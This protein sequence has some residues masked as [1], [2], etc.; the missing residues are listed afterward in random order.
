MYICLC[1]VVTERQI[2]RAVHEGVSSLEE[3]RATLSVST[4]CGCCAEAAEA[5]LQMALEERPCRAPA[6]APR[7]GEASAPAPALGLPGR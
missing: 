6:R 2:H 1:H 4:G 3:L 5:C 7:A